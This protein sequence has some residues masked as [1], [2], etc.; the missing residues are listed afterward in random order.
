MQNQ[1]FNTTI[2]VEQSPTEVFNVI[3][4][5]RSWWSG[6]YGEEF[7]GNSDKPGDEFS[8]RAGGGVHY[9]KQ[10]LVEL[11][12][13]K[14]LVW[15]VTDSRLTFIEDTQEWVGTKIR[16]DISEKG[17]RTEILFIHEG[18]VPQIECYNNCSAAWTQY[19][20]GRLL[21]ALNNYSAEQDSKL[22]KEKVA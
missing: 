7:E 17:N 10:K 6:L 19:V 16:F 22:E 14:R 2:T 1:D 12:P 9:S 5:V 8:F 21:A 15:L 13:N 20:Q 3:K 18:L 11:I 4:D